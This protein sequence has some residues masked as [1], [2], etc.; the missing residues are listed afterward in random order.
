MNVD[1][2]DDILKEI[3][4]QMDSRVNDSNGNNTCKTSNANIEYI[5]VN[6]NGKSKNV[7]IRVEFQFKRCSTVK[8]CKYEKY[9]TFRN[10]NSLVHLSSC[11]SNVANNN[12]VIRRSKS[13]TGISNGSFQVCNLMENFKSSNESKT[14]LASI[15]VNNEAKSLR[16][17]LSQDSSTRVDL[18]SLNEINL[19]NEIQ[20]DEP[21]ND[22]SGSSGMGGNS[23]FVTP[24]T[25]CTIVLD[26]NET[27]VIR[28]VNY[29]GDN[30]GMDVKSANVATT[31]NINGDNGTTVIGNSFSNFSMSNKNTNPFLAMDEIPNSNHKFNDT[32]YIENESTAVPIGNVFQNMEKT[33][34]SDKIVL[35][36]EVEKAISIVHTHDDDSLSLDDDDD[37]DVCCSELLQNSNRNNFTTNP[38]HSHKSCTSLFPT[39]DLDRKTKH[40]TRKHNR[41]KEL[42]TSSDNIITLS[43]VNRRHI[44]SPKHETNSINDENK[45]N[46]KL[47]K[48]ITEFNRRIIADGGAIKTIVNGTD[49]YRSHQSY[50]I[51]GGIPTCPFQRQDYL[52]P[53]DDDTEID[54]NNIDANPTKKSKREKKDLFGFSLHRDKCGGKIV[55]SIK[56]FNI[57]YPYKAK[58]SDDMSMKDADKKL[59]KKSLIKIGQKCGLRLSKSPEKR[60][61]EQHNE[62]TKVLENHCDMAASTST[63]SA[64][65][66]NESHTKAAYKS[67]KSEID[68][69]RNLHY[70]DAFLNENFDKISQP[71]GSCSIGKISRRKKYGHKRT[72]SCS[73]NIDYDNEF[74]NFEFDV[75][76]DTVDTNLLPLSL[77][78]K[79]GITLFQDEDNLKITFPASTTTSSYYYRHNNLRLKQQTN[80]SSSDSFSTYNSKKS[81]VHTKPAKE[82]IYSMESANGDKSGKSNTTSSSLSSDYASVYSPSG[83]S[84]LPCADHRQKTSYDQQQL[85]LIEKQLQM[86]AATS[87]SSSSRYEKRSHNNST[88]NFLNVDK[89]FLPPT[90]LP[91]SSKH[92]SI[93]HF[94]ITQPD[95]HDKI[96]YQYENQLPYHE[97][98][99]KHYQQLSKS[100]VGSI[101]NFPSHNPYTNYRN[102]SMSNGSSYGHHH[103]QTNA[104]TTGTTVVTPTQNQ[105]YSHR[106]IVS[107]SRKQ[108]GEVVLEYEC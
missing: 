30:I 99:L 17:D 91:H 78:T 82:I 62:R 75:S 103:Y 64:T 37:D 43:D 102:T 36:N 22:G 89:P 25:L 84:Y 4:F 79:N 93:D 2:N 70:L 13:S 106:V 32:E 100:T 7:D 31:E 65:H 42:R 77:P 23:L 6:G 40:R 66:P 76:G 18:V 52:K 98:Y 68:L 9:Q 92:H 48:F 51:I 71:K 56:K 108:R 33:E 96:K 57:S 85:D 81:K 10:S 26:A 41:N 72:K 67:Y 34:R 55:P 95:I 58:N 97:D 45:K 35:P 46:E 105:N 50:A 14:T 87:S 59:F 69:T 44:H 28:K 29:I 80:V 27:E 20:V 1:R 73:K 38:S 61:F 101:S 19:D 8:Y 90:T 15:S 11:S 21:Y 74:S 107:K 16:E 3:P 39:N 86:N 54:S 88:D 53:D 47:D 94:E 60:S 5:T 83:S 49:D 63:S 104:T 12:V 24:S